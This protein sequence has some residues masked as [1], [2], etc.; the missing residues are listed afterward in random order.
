MSPDTSRGYAL[1]LSSAVILSTTAVFIRHLTAHH[2]LDP[3][4]LAVW[5]A[6]FAAATL[7]AALAISH[8]L[9]TATGQS[10]KRIIRTLRPLR[11]AIITIEGHEFTADPTI[12]ADARALLDRLPPITTTGH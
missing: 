3:L 8:H 1:A 7:F 11:S 9:T 5:R 6:G 4:V 2:H 10:L 12:T